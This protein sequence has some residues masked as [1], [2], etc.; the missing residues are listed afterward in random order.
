M[1]RLGASNPAISQP[2]IN[3]FAAAC[4]LYKAMGFTAVTLR[5][6]DQDDAAGQY[7]CGVPYNPSVAQPVRWAVG[8][9]IALA[10]AAAGGL[11][12]VFAVGFSGFHRFIN[13]G[14]GADS[15]GAPGNLG[16]W[17]FL[18]FVIDPT[19]YIGMPTSQPFTLNGQTTTAQVAS[20]IGDARVIRWIYDGEWK[21]AASD[22][23]LAIADQKAL[24]WFSYFKFLV[25][26]NSATNAEACLYALAGPGDTQAISIQRIQAL[27]PYQPDVI[28]LEGYA[29]GL[30]TDITDFL[31]IIQAVS[32]LGIPLF[33]G[34]WGDNTA[35]KE[36]WFLQN[37]AQ[38]VA[39]Q[40]PGG[41]AAFDGAS[42]WAGDAVVADY[43]ISG[44]SPFVALAA[45]P[46]ASVKTQ[47]PVTPWHWFNPPASM[48]MPWTNPAAYTLE[49]GTPNQ[50]S[51]GPAN[52]ALG[53]LA[54]T[55]TE[56][57]QNGQ[58]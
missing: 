6:W 57:F 1:D 35:T 13:M 5:I 52:Y 58:P 55:L 33:L 51:S 46:I 24:S 37:I 17:S 42:F 38:I 19:P 23:E 26:Y 28:G 54:E 14:Y 20:L 12:V 16:P 21:L 31:A 18:Q 11:K 4:A 49:T 39:G 45:S 34:E 32:G 7:G 22:G 29:A 41:P 30:S 43:T 25:H 48:D 53:P 15:K 44:Q 2:A 3:N 27:A 47:Y 10:I 9:A 36:P 56:L 8:Q 40:W 50:V